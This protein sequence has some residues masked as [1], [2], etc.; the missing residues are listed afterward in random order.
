MSKA[1]IAAFRSSRLMALISGKTLAVPFESNFFFEKVVVTPTHF[2]PGDT[3]IEL[4][5]WWRRETPREQNIQFEHHEVDMDNP[6]EQAIYLFR[7]LRPTQGHCGQ[8]SALCSV[9]PAS[10][11]YVVNNPQL[12]IL[13]AGRISTCSTWQPFLP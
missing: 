8:R 5:L 13:S 3:N 7:K 1:W 6:E 12:T 10:Y 4:W 2:I 11:C 9:A